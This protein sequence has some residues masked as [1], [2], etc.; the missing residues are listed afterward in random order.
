MKKNIEKEL[1]IL[2]DKDTFFFLLS[3]YKNKKEIIQKN[4]YYSISN[5]TIENSNIAIRLRYLN[6]KIV[7]TLKENT[8]E[9]LL[10]YEKEFSINCKIESIWNDSEIQQILQNHNMN[11]KLYPIVTIE[12]KRTVVDLENAELCFDIST[13]NN[14]T[15]YEIE[16]EY[17]SEHN[18][19]DVFNK[20]L[21]QGCLTYTQNCYSKLKR[22]LQSYDV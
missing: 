8:K 4:I 19:K 16:Y 9:G 11:K 7:F 15:D 6:N 18:G 2:V 14:I 12:T 20:I 5:E 1:K 21:N 17:K 3:K 22:A 13:Y 10:E